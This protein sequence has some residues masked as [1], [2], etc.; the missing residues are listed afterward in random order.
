VPSLPAPMLPPVLSVEASI[1]R[2]FQLLA[3]GLATPHVD[4]TAALAHHGYVQ[5][6]PINVCGRM[7][8]L[9]LRPR[10]ADYREGDLWRH[11]HG[12][13]APLPAASRT[14]IE[15]HLPSNNLLV[16]LEMSA[17]PHLRAAMAA[18]ARRAGT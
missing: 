6:A 17:W 1:A 8:D 14:A 12:G 16:V 13:A 9:I 10:V 11:T 5:I 15:H 18:R 3:L 4:V 2:R 7:H